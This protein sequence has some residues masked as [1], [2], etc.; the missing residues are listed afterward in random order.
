MSKYKYKQC[1]RPCY[2]PGL[3]RTHTLFI[4]RYVSQDG[5]RDALTAASVGGAA[6]AR[7]RPPINPNPISHSH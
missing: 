6:Q 4:S 1:R 7:P 2:C 3:R 5:C